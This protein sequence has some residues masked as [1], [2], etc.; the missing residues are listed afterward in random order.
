MT[1]YRRK[2]L[3]IDA[4]QAGSGKDVPDWL[5]HRLP[6]MI[7]GGGWYVNDPLI[8]VIPMTNEL[9]EKTYEVCDD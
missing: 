3:E 7:S 2:P 5:A 6:L 1:R 8:G 4:Y 9:F